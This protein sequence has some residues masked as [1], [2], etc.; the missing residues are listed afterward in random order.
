VNFAFFAS[1][2]ARRRS[3]RDVTEDILP[4]DNS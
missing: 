2:F 1:I 3:A 4:M